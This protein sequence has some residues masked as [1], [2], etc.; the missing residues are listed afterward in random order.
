MRWD[1]KDPNSNASIVLYSAE[2]VNKELPGNSLRADVRKLL[3]ASSSAHQSHLRG[4]F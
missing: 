2:I 3:L 4:A 1:M